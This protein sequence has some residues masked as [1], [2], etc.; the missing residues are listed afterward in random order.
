[1]CSWGLQAQGV[2]KWWHEHQVP[3]YYQN[4]IQDV[5]CLTSRP[6]HHCWSIKKGLA[7]VLLNAWQPGQRPSECPTKS[8]ATPHYRSLN[9]LFNDFMSFAWSD[10]IPFSTL[11]ALRSRS[12]HCQKTWRWTSALAPILSP[13]GMWTSRPPRTWRR[14]SLQII[15]ALEEN[16]SWA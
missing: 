8:P 15:P 2:P 1:M 13:E 9:L 16:L 4:N 14:S 11:R 6:E 3:F 12:V 5:E 7:K 10:N